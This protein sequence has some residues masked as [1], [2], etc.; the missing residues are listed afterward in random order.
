M[1]DL[2]VWHR[3]EDIVTLFATHNNI[4]IPQNRQL[5]RQ[6]ALFDI[7]AS[8][9]VVHP[10]LGIAEGIQDAYPERVCKCLEKFGFELTQ[11]RHPISL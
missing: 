10:D 5:L 3:V 2:A 11:F 6:V 1:E 4:P 9:Q 8:A 7:Q